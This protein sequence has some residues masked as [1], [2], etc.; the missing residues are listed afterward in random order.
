MENKFRAW[1]NKAKEWL[2]GYN[3]PNLGGF[4]L[5]GEC[6][7]FN[8]WGA[9]INRFYL[10]Q[11]DRKPEDLKIMRS[12]GWKDDYGI[13]IYEDDYLSKEGAYVVYSDRLACWCFTF[14]DDKDPPTPLFHSK[15]PLHVCGNIWE[16]CTSGSF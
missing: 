2:L 5:T 10:Q 16:G 15:E 1:D 6:V 9:I 12:I 8:E 14:K 11:K 7:L 4:S 3:Y 13:P